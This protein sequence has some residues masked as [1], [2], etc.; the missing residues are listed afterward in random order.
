[1]IYFLKISLSSQFPLPEG[2]TNAQI[3]FWELYKTKMTSF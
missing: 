2:S 3:Q 1:M